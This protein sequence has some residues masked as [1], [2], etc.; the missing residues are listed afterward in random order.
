MTGQIGSS[1]ST[2]TAAHGKETGMLSK[3]EQRTLTEIEHELRSEDLA[4]TQ[5][6]ERLGLRCPQEWLGMTARGWL[7]SA[8]LLMGFAVLTGSGGLALIA[9]SV[10]G[11]SGGLWLTDNARSSDEQGPPRP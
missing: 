9:L 2:R 4:F 10:A 3:A 5:R 1:A 7:F 8:A 6:F 11:V